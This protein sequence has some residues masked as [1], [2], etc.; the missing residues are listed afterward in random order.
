MGVIVS[1]LRGVNLGPH[2]RIKM[3]ALREV[4]ESLGLADVQTYVQSGNVVFRSSERDLKKLA[5]RIEAAIEKKFG[6]RSDVILR[7]AAEMRDV[8]ARNPFAARSGIEPNR[9][10]VTFLASDPGQEL[11]DKV[12]AI[13]ADP[14][15][16]H[17][18]GREMYIYFPN[19][20]ARPKLSLPAIEK[21]LKITGTG[22]NWNSVV[23]LLELAENIELRQA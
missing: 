9:Y 6:F 17:F 13:K 3:D 4:Y 1:M 22:R 18:D 7:T 15:E 12:R 2:R 19:G 21:I 11:R 8:I 16:L 20:L 5:K 23:K 14:E 10:L